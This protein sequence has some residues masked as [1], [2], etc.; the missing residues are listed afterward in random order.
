MKHRL[1]VLLAFLALAG[2]GT[3]PSERA[4]SGGGIGAGTGAAAGAIAGTSIANAALLGAGVGIIAGALSSPEWLNLGEPVWK[5]LNIQFG[6]AVFPN[7]QRS[8]LVR[9]IQYQL[10]DQGFYHGPLSGL[11]GKQTEAAIRS[12]Q[13]HEGLPVDGRPSEALLE[14]LESAKQ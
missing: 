3:L 13:Q 1:V 10:K 5:P 2:C 9:R 7:M 12:Y 11:A 14:R 8:D 4:V 6:N